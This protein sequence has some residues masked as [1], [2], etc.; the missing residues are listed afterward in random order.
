[1]GAGQA[2]C[3]QEEEYVEEECGVVTVAPQA[4]VYLV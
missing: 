1:M 2:G 4:Y 3:I